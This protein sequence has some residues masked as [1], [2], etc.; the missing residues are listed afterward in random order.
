MLVREHMTPNPVTITPD[1]SVTEA[2]RLM[3]E[4]TSPICALNSASIASNWGHSLPLMNDF[5]AFRFRVVRRCRGYRYGLR[6]YRRQ[7]AMNRSRNHTGYG[8]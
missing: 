3:R 5:G 4:A 2:L 1:A 7:S 6:W 8:A